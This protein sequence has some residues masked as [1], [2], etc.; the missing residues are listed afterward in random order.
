[1][2]P[3]D[4]ALD[5]LSRAK[6]LLRLAPKHRESR[7]ALARA[8]LDAR[9][10]EDARRELD[11]LALERAS[12]RV[13][14][15]IAELEAQE[16]GDLGQVRIWLARAAEAPR[17]PCWMADGMILPEWMPLSPVSGRIGAAEWR[18]PPEPGHRPALLE[19][20]LEAALAQGAEADRAATPPALLPKPEPSPEA[21]RL[22]EKHPETP[23][24]EP[25]L[26]LQG[27]LGIIPDDPGPEPREGPQRM[28]AG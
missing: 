28:G 16:R 26:I 13:C 1:V 17:D 18:E 5:R 2:R 23:Q 20:R 14:H 22:P 27:P 9:E 12:V 11:D 19:A 25:P 10:F 7:L 4:S 6:T 24:P 15:L 3:G 21:S 8:Y